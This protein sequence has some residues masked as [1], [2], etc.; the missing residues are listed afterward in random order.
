MARGNRQQDLDIKQMTPG[1]L[2]RE[3]MKLRT[4]IRKHR[5]AAENARC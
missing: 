5:D 1:Q 4:A 3:I 2:R